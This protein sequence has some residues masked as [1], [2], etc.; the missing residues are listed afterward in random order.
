LQLQL[1][2]EALSI[3][4]GEGLKRAAHSLKGSL[5]NLAANNAC[6]MAASLEELACRNEMKFA[7]QTL[8]RLEPE[9]NQVYESL[10]ALY[11]KQ[12]AVLGARI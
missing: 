10:A 7:G 5:G 9:L 11:Q 1:A 6:G 2:R 3:G 12:A 4:D 8:D